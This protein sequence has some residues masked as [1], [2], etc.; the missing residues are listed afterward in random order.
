MDNQTKEKKEEGM[1]GCGL[2]GSLGFLLVGFRRTQYITSIGLFYKNWGFYL[3][4]V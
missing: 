3:D 2:D 1:R 4:G